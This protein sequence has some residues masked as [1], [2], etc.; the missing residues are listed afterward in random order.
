[1]FSLSPIPRRCRTEKLTERSRGEAEEAV[2]R[3]LGA[4]YRI[5]DFTA[6]SE[7]SNGL[8]G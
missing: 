8:G 2:I 6:T 7:D 3:D 5:G 4:D 1:V